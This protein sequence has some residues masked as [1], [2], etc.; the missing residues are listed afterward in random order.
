MKPTITGMI[1][2]GTFVVEKLHFQSR[3][4]LYVTGNLYRPKV[5]EGKL[6]AVVLFMRH[7]NRGRNGHKAFMQ[8]HGM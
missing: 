5:R 4:G 3:P 6:P 7:Y 1:E 2:R 8:D